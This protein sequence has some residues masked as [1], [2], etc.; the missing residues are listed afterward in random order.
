MPIAALRVPSAPTCQ[1]FNFPPQ[2]HP[3]GSVLT[4]C[5]KS[6]VSRKTEIISNRC[7][8]NSAANAFLIGKNQQI[9]CR[10]L[11]HQN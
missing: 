4:A 6:N 3:G 2:N 11:R 5:V 1:V 9:K 8:A 7:F 10:N